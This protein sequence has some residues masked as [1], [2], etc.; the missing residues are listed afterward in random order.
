MELIE[1]IKDF[2]KKYKSK[3]IILLITL[4][5]LFILFLFLF[6]VNI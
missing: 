2:L 4:I 6:Q 5:N 3:L 1:D